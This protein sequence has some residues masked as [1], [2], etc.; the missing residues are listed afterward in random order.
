MNVRRY[1]IPLLVAAVCYGAIAFDS[2]TSG[3]GTATLSKAALVH[4]A[5]VLVLADCGAYTG[6]AD[7]MKIGTTKMTLLHDTTYL[8]VR[9]TAFYLWA[10]AS[11][12]DTVYCYTHASVS[13]HAWVAVAYTGCIN[14]SSFYEGWAKGMKNHNDPCSL[15]V[16]V[17][18]GTADR[19]VIG[20]NAYVA[21]ANTS[22]AIAVAPYNGETERSESDQSGTSKRSASVQA[23]EYSSSA[24]HAVSAIGTGGANP[25][26]GLCWAFALL[27]YVAPATSTGN[28][29]LMF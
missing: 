21:G 9:S 7:S 1:L 19:L 22:T 23:E 26:Y 13:P 29:F 18:A 11:G 4:G 28:F 3:G 25:L 17:G 8:G 15:A 6:Y 16:T 20:L 24:G 14:G 5:N 10:T 12:T 27:P 2:Q